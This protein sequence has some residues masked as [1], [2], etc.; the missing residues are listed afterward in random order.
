MSA[1]GLEYYSDIKP[2]K[3]HDEDVV[4]CDE[5]HLLFGVFDGMGGL[6]SASIASRS[7]S[8]AV[9]EYFSSESNESPGAASAKQLVKHAL[10][11]ADRRVRGEH[12]NY[13]HHEY[14]GTTGSIVHFYDESGA[15]RMAYGHVGDSRIYLLSE[16]QL[17]QM[18]V[19]EG[20]ANR[21][22]NFLGGLKR[23]RQVGSCA[24]KSRDRVLLCSDGVTGDF[25]YEILTEEEI[26][27]TLS[28]GSP[29]RAVKKL[30][31]MSRKNDDKS[32][33]VIDLL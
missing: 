14:M 26:A 19:D 7:A 3:G 8:Q 30:I 21:I 33:I 31:K 4:L 20:Y 15:P 18:T 11:F 9:Q 24:L 27:K 2:L 23:V 10:E 25:G 5:E 13:P 1:V 29:R 16:G 22:E 32:A 28:S 12:S 17:S 6:P